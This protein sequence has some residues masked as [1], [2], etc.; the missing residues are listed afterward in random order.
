[1]TRISGFFLLGL[2][3]S[4][5]GDALAE[6]D[7]DRFDGFVYM[8]GTVEDY[9]GPAAIEAFG[10]RRVGGKLERVGRYL[11]GGNNLL[12]IGGAQQNALVSDGSHVYSVN[13]GSNTVSAL[14]IGQGGELSLIQQVSSGGSR[15]VSIAIYGDHLYVA[16]AGHSPIEDAQ[17][18]T[19]IG[20]TIRPDGSLTR[21]PC[22]PATATPGELGNIIANLAINPKGT[23]MVV[24]GLLSNKIDSFR[25]DQQGCLEKRQTLSGGG[26]AFSV[27]FRPN[28]NDAVISRAFP[29]VF[30][31]EQ[32]PGMGSFVVGND[33]SI[34]EVDTYVDP[35]KSD[36]GLRDPCWVDFARDGLHFWVSSFIPRSLNAFGL[37]RHGKLKLLSEYQPPDSVPDPSDPGASVLVGSFDIATDKAKDHLYQIRAYA[38]PEGQVNVPGA[39]HTF[40]V[41]GNWDVDAGLRLVQVTPLPSDFEIPGVTGLVFVDRTGN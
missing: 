14:S 33:G 36:D 23:A 31:D 3:L 25:I 20:F 41:T 13:P 10:R 40:K 35:D 9:S 18:A 19:I 1:M 38:V 32:A 24:T 4:F 39:I 21:L 22:A 30:P 8:L 15:P 11:T 26:G 34:T 17:P 2:M 27:N 5:Q 12:E 7:S 28:S 16:N 29:E 6:L 37:D